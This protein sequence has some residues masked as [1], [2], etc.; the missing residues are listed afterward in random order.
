MSKL[1]P[2]EVI[3]SLISNAHTQFTEADR[4]WLTA[5]NE[6]QL[7]LL[8]P[9]NIPEIKVN[10]EEAKPQ[11]FQELLNSAPADVQAQFKYNADKFAEHKAGLIT[12]IKA[13]ERNKLT[14]EQLGA[15][16]IEVLEATAD[17]LAPVAPVANYAGAFGMVTDPAGIKQN[18]LD[19]PTMEP[20]KQ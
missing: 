12:R 18:A 5:L 20:V 2:C 16:S 6:G 7:E 9:V 3:S 10:K 17:S 8:V 13:N 15:L 1:T 4:E 11:S 14:D 19:L